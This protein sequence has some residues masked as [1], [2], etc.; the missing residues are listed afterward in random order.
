[1]RHIDDADAV[2]FEFADQI[3]QFAHI[4]LLQWFG[5]LVQKQSLRICGECPRDLHDMPLR[6]R[7]L[8]D[9][10]ADRHPEFFGCHPLEQALGFHCTAMPCE[11]RGRELK[12]FQH[13]Q[14]VCE[15]RMLIH[16]TDAVLTH[17]RRVRRRNVLAVVIDGTGIGAQNAGS[18]ADQ[19]GFARAIFADN[20][21]NL[22]GHDEDVDALQCVHRTEA[23]ADTGQCHNRNVR[24]GRR[25]DHLYNVM[26][27]ATAASL[28][29][30]PHRSAR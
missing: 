26:H 8:G 5:R 19:R 3:E 16:D 30:A 17:S 12:I 20:G 10:L 18:D 29:A 2:G 27:G 23:F 28:Q 15:R 14:V 25:C 7:Q 21:M 6:Q 1:M 11:H 4:G 24:R 9:A 22:S 13:C